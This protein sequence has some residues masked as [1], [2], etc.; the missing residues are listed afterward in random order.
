M[1]ARDAALPRRSAAKT[2]IRAAIA[3][4]IFGAVLRVVPF[5]DVAARLRD[6]SWPLFALGTA[7]FFPTFL[8]QAV[9]WRALFAGGRES[10]PGVWTFFRLICIGQFASLFLPSSAGGDVVRAAMLGRDERAYAA[11]AGSIVLGRAIG[12]LALLAFV[13]IGFLVEPSH[14][15]SVPGLVPFCAV[16]A[17]AAFVAVALLFRAPEGLLR[18]LERRPRLVPL[19]DHLRATR[20]LPLRT[21]ALVAFL[22]AAIQ[23][24]SNLLTVVLYWAVGMPFPA[25]GILTLVPVLMLVNMVPVSFFNVGVREGAMIVL[26]SGLPGVTPDLCVAAALLGYVSVL[27]PS[28]AGAWFFVARGGSARKA[29]ETK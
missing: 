22:S 7:L 2:A 18:A 9:R 14:L 6:V 8:I 26:F 24:L 3:A 5:D 27:V 25:I 12:V 11:S 13:W 16:A 21:K 1:D 4:V 28:A 19:A 10:V 17:V 29:E 15:S 23:L 20:L